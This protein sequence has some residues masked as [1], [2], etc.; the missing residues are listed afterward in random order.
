MQ[1]ERNELVNYKQ[2]SCDPNRRY[3]RISVTPD[4]IQKINKRYGIDFTLISVMANIFF[5][6]PQK[7]YMTDVAV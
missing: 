4:I 1:N 6:V 2:Y 5:P 7:I 3:V